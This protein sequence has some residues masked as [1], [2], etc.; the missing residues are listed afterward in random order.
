MG[1][2]VM[3]MDGTSTLEAAPGGGQ[4]GTN[5]LEASVGGGA[6][7]WDKHPGATPLPHP[8]TEC[9]SCRGK[10]GGGARKGQQSRGKT[11]AREQRD[12]RVNCAPSTGTAFGTTPIPQVLHKMPP[13][14]SFFLLGTQ[15]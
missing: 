14:R 15:R 12:N 4:D 10:G 9:E 5:P 3:G 6:G 2:G 7:G 1:V 13:K 11:W 8:D